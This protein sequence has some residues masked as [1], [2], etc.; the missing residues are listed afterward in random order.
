MRKGLKKEVIC[1]SVSNLPKT[2]NPN[3]F[4]TDDAD[5]IGFYMDYFRF[6]SSLSELSS[7]NP[8]EEK[9]YLNPLKSG[10]FKMYDFELLDTLI[11]KGDSI[12]R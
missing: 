1:H 2:L 12:L 10:T 11:V 8:S 6:R 7:T 5:P 9:L 3:A 4:F